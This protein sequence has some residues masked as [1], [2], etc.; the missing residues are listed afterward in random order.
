MCLDRFFS[1]NVGFHGLNSLD[2]TVSPPFTWPF[3]EW[4]GDFSA[5]SEHLS[6]SGEGG[7]NFPASSEH[8]AKSKNPKNPGGGRNFCRGNLTPRACKGGSTIVPRADRYVGR[9]AG[10]QG[11]SSSSALNRPG[12]TRGFLF[13]LWFLRPLPPPEYL[14]LLLC[15][16][17]LSCEGFP[18]IFFRVLKH[19]TPDIT[20]L[21]PPMITL[22][23][24]IAFGCAAVARGVLRRRPNYVGM[25]VPGTFDLSLWSLPTMCEMKFFPK[26]SVHSQKNDFTH[27]IKL[28]SWSPHL[29]PW[30]LSLII[31]FPIYLFPCSPSPCLS[32]TA[33]PFFSPSFSPPIAHEWVHD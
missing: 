16:T 2:M 12:F 13:L 22:L 29:N 25:G 18:W 31:C 9:C 14:I 3:R 6:E 5:V 27:L 8:V 33:P 1:Q 11:F 26:V 21:V 23:L 24:F 19:K 32:S 20:N 15:P 17:F 7:M 30:I 28:N 4:G 10:S